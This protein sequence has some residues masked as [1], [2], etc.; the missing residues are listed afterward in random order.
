MMDEKLRYLGWFLLAH[1]GNFLDGCLT[2]LA[3]SRGAEELNPFM[4]ILIESSPFAFLAVKFILFAF[5]IDFIS[6][7]KP[8]YLKWVATMYLLVTAW[9][10]SFILTN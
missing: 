3:V 7:F 1:L 9:H 5:A 2:L 6:K 4:A 8:N 10:L